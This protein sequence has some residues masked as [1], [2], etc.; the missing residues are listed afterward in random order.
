MARTVRWTETAAEDLNE[1]A[2]FIARDSQYYAAAFVREVRRAAR[3][4]SFSP[5]R[6]RLVPESDRTDI[7]EIFVKSYRLI[8]QVT[9]REVFILAFIHGARDLASLWK[10]REG[11]L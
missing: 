2:A 8:Y 1:A 11:G 9:N 3:S 4:L 7:R 10:R 6:G 5:E